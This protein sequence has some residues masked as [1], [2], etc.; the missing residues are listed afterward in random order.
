MSISKTAM[1]GALMFGVAGC[2]GSESANNQASAD[3]TANAVQAEAS[4]PFADAEQKMNQAMMAAVGPTAGDTW[5]RMMI[6]HHQGAID[7]S[8]VALQQNLPADVAKMAQDA[9]DKQQK[10]VADLQKLVQQGTPDPKTMDLYHPAMQQ[11][12][13]AMTNAKGGDIA[14]TFMRK[15]LAHHQGGVTLSDVA[16]KNGVTGAVRAQ[17]EK[18]RA[19]QQNDAEMTEAMIPGKPMKHGGEPSASMNHTAMSED[20]NGMDMNSMNHM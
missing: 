1:V 4:D 10:E 2:G 3:M 5:V 9:I 8:R 18:T 7:M 20:M 14:E 15:M 17:V 6:A 11:M 12:E 16:L 19:G 13:D